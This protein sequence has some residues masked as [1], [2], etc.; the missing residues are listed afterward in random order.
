[1]AFNYART[2]FPFSIVA[3]RYLVRVT[4]TC[5]YNDR[6]DNHMTQCFRTSKW[7]ISHLS[8][9]KQVISTWTCYSSFSIWAHWHFG[10]VRELR[11]VYP[12]GFQPLA[13]FWWKTAPSPHA[14]A[15]R[16]I[17]SQ[18]LSGYLSR[19]R[20]KGYVC[21]PDRCI[22]PGGALTWETTV[23]GLPRN[24]NDR[25]EECIKYRGIQHLGRA[26]FGW[27]VLILHILMFLLLSRKVHFAK[28]QS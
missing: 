10:F 11:D 15:L 28:A 3:L 9:C 27:V 12:T 8:F 14:E 1:M 25:P 2:H 7:K 13:C 20:S 18:K 22:Y 19:E 6:T 16:T 26:P 4:D 23:L 17:D 21:L 24:Q 5:L